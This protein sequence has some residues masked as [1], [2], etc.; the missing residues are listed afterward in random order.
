MQLMSM[1]S[2]HLAPSIIDQQK[3]SLNNS[4]KQ[5]EEEELSSVVEDSA[6]DSSRSSPI[7]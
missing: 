2:R 5:H 7:D 3:Y 6:N 1:V 4:S